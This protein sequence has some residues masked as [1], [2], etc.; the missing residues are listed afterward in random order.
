MVPYTQTIPGTDITFSYD[1]SE[2]S[3]KELF[4]PAE[5]YARLADSTLAISKTFIDLTAAR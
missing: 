5:P 1:G 4:A 2:S 3:F